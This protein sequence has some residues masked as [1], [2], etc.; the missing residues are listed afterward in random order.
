MMDPSLADASDEE[1]ADKLNGL[2]IDWQ[3]R[4]GIYTSLEEMKVPFEH[5]ETLVRD[6]MDCPD[7]YVA[8][9]VP[10]AEEVRQMYLNMWSKKE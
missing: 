7:T 6:T 2:I 4:L 8:P 9:A 3:K 1:A 5:I 10:T